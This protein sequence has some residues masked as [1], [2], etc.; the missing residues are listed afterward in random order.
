MH[1]GFGRKDGHALASLGLTADFS[2]CSSPPKPVPRETEHSSDPMRAVA[3]LIF[4]ICHHASFAGRNKRRKEN[5]GKTLKMVNFMCRN[6]QH[7]IETKVKMQTQEKKI[8]VGL[9]CSSHSLAGFL[10]FLGPQRWTG[11]TDRQSTIR[12]WRP[13]SLKKPT[14]SS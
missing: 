9:R 10:V 1:R 7:P 5:N 6:S 11:S 4:S 2:R 12:T 13:T 8:R 3:V 14:L